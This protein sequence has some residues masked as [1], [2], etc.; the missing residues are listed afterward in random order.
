MQSSPMGSDRIED[1]TGLADEDAQ[2]EQ[3]A[4]AFAAQFMTAAAGKSAMPA[5]SALMPAPFARR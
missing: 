4:A 1:V 5:P 3:Q 2:L